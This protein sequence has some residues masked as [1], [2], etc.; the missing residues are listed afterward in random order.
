MEETLFKQLLD[1]LLH[2]DIT[3]AERVQFDALLSG[4]EASRL[5]RSLWQDDARMEPERKARMKAYVMG[6]VGSRQPVRRSRRGVWLTISAV[7]AA[8]AVG[9]FSG[10]YLTHDGFRPEEYALSAGNAQTSGITLPDGTVVRLNSSSRL[11][12]TSAYNRRERTVTLSGEAFFEVA[13]DPARPFT[14]QTGGMSVRAVG[15]QFNVRAYPSDEDITAT[16]VEGKVIVSSADEHVMLA[17]RQEA[18]FVRSTGR[19]NKRDVAGTLVPWMEGD[20]VFDNASLTHLAEVLERTFNVRTVIQDPS[21][22]QRCYTGVVRHKS[23][24][25]VL[26]LISSTSDVGCRQVGDTIYFHKRR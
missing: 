2:G 16:L 13:P 3:D 1:K 21:L 17:P 15:T 9:I 18:V 25:N 8:L 22:E 23:L 12:Y 7:A 19:M 5:S 11:T 20:L 26:D 6:A 4:P 10:I 14:V 24:D